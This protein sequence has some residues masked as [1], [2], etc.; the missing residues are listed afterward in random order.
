M[1]LCVREPALPAG[2]ECA[3]RD[4]GEERDDVPRVQS[5]RGSTPAKRIGATTHAAVTRR[6]TTFAVQKTARARA[7]PDRHS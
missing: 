6:A 4:P 2:E 5:Q 1:D 7:V 3:E